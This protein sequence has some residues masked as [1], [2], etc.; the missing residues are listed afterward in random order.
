MGETESQR[1][2]EEERWD[3]GLDTRNSP[4]RRQGT[5]VKWPLRQKKEQMRKAR[6]FKEGLITQILLGNQTR[7]ALR[8]G[9]VQ[10]HK[11]D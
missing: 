10:L 3:P 6:C 9:W 1:A 5:E 7:L 11:I 4:V 8:F 2:S